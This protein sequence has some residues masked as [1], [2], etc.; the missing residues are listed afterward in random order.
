MDL[1]AHLVPRPAATFL[2][3]VA[4]VSMEGRDQCI[5]EGDLVV[6]D[7][8]IPPRDGHIIAAELDRELCLKVLRRRGA[9]VWLQPANAG[10]APIEI[11]PEREFVVWG[12]VTARISEFAV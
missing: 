8:S 5:S 2:L 9:R 12:V 10:F 4:G 6:V 11:T 3:R 7:R 1:H